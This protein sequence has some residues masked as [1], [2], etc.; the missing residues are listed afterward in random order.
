VRRDASGNEEVLPVKVDVKAD[1][2]RYRFQ[3]LKDVVS[4][5]PAE[6]GRHYD[7]SKLSPEDRQRLGL[8]PA[9]KPEPAAQ[10]K[11]EPGGNGEKIPPTG[12]GIRVDGDCDNWDVSEGRPR[13]PRS[14]GR[15]DGEPGN[16]NWYSN[17]PA[18]NAITGGKPIRFNNGQ[19]DFTPWAKMSVNLAPGVLT[20]NHRADYKATVEQMAKQFGSQKAAEQYIKDNGLTPHHASDT[21]IQ[22]VPMKLNGLVP[23]VGSASGLRFSPRN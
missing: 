9:A 17:N 22:L 3:P 2:E 8:P 6:L 19:P 21:C 7:L 13:L 1:V 14:D 16:S 11:T 4:F 23:H 12:N 5:D 15:W 10:A 20:G 18:V